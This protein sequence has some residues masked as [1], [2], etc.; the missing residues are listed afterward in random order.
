MPQ[1][2]RTEKMIHILKWLIARAKSKRSPRI[3]ETKRYIESEICSM[4]ATPRTVQKYLLRLQAHGYV[5]E[6]GGRLICTQTGK[7]WLE[8]KV[9]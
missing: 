7:N 1:P 8:K 3:L 6:D 4:G 2:E 9:S 5:R